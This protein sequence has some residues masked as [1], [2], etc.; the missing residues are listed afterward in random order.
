MSVMF[1]ATTTGTSSSITC[2]TMYRLRDSCVASTTITTRSGDSNGSSP[3]ITWIAISS[4]RL[5]ADRLY[6]PGTSSTSILRPLASS[7]VPLFR[8]TVTPG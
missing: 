4:S 5:S 1:S 3:A 8:S 2:S 6:V 7:S